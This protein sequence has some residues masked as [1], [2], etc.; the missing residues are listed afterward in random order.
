MFYSNGLAVPQDYEQAVAWWRKAADQGDAGAQF[1]LGFLYAEGRGVPQD[2]AAGDVVVPQ[3]GGSGRRDRAVQSR[4]SLRHRAQHHPGL[5]TSGGV[6]PQGRGAGS[7]LEAQ[8]NLGSLYAEGRGVPAG[9]RAG[10]DVVATG[11][12]TGQRRSRRPTL[13][14][15]TRLDA[16]CRRT[17]RKR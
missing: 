14:C 15:S 16:V 9:L 11:G 4:P 3:G 7:I 17:L 1:N 8:I 12:G 13:D 2:D 6:V 5:R 10:H